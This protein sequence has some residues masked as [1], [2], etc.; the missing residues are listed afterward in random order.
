[1]SFLE[2]QFPTN[3]SNGAH[4]GPEYSTDIVTVNSGYESRNIRWSTPR[5]KYDVSH[6]VR[7]NDELKQLV[8]FFRLVKGRAHGFRFRDYADYTVTHSEGQFARNVL[9]ATP[10]QVG[11]GDKVYQLYKVYDFDI[12]YTTRKI[13]KPED[14]TIEVKANGSVVPS[15]LYTIDY[16]TGLLT[17]NT[18]AG[19]DT[20]LTLYSNSSPANAITNITKQAQCVITFTNPHSFL[21]GD[22]IYITSVG[23]M[24]ELNNLYHTITAVGTSTITISTNSTTYTTWTSGGTISRYGVTPEN[25][26]TV[27]WANHGKSVGTSVYLKEAGSSGTWQSTHEGKSYV[28]SSVN[29]NSFVLTA[30]F[31]GAGNPSA[32]VTIT[33]FYESG[34]TLTWAGQFDVPCRFDTDYMNAS[35]DS[36]IHGSWQSIPIIEIRI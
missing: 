5:A 15:N 31:S 3:I 10:S 25:N 28:I 29:T 4:G 35:V 24:T 7:T 18:T 8:S 13:V 27:N 23:G 9:G 17:F 20:N 12:Y 32:T 19:V 11:T 21:V 2:I 14:G 26:P 22:R 1:M 16:T 6:A 36:S 30:N 33:S 34:T